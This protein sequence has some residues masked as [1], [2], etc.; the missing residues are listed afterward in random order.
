[1]FALLNRFVLQAANGDIEGLTVFNAEQPFM[2]PLAQAESRFGRLVLGELHTLMKL[3]CNRGS[4]SVTIPVSDAQI[5]MLERWAGL[6]FTKDH[7]GKKPKTVY[8][9]RSNL[10]FEKASFRF[11][12]FVVSLNHFLAFCRFHLWLW[13]RS[14]R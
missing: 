11:S 7:D 12:L 5:K 10:D 1:L 4:G 9:P 6:P 14:C 8:H 3:P 13:Y 2:E